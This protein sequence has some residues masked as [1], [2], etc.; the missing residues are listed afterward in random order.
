MRTQRT[1]HTDSLSITSNGVASSS[2]SS[3][4]K[5]LSALRICEKSSSRNL[6]SPSLDHENDRSFSDAE[7]AI[8]ATENVFN[9]PGILYFHSA[10]IFVY[11]TFYRFYYE[12]RFYVQDP[13]PHLQHHLVD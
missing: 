13:V 2:P 3:K 10:T 4:K 5:V 11:R 8:T 9:V 7:E 1:D 12:V 6:N